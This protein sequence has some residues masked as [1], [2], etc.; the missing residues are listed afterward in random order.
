MDVGLNQAIW[1][2]FTLAEMNSRLEIIPPEDRVDPDDVERDIEDEEAFHKET[3]AKANA[4][5]ANETSEFDEMFKP[6]KRKS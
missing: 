1:D 6:P 3:I 5:L 2:Y 4:M